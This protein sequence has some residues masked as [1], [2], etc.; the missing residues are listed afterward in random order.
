MRKEQARGGLPNSAADPLPTAFY[1]PKRYRNSAA[2]RADQIVSKLLIYNIYSMLRGR[3]SGAET[4]FFPADREC[5][6][7]G[8]GLVRRPRSG[9]AAQISRIPDVRDAYLLIS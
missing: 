3:F 1:G 5:D 7:L 6:R 9:G 4:G 8:P 2:G